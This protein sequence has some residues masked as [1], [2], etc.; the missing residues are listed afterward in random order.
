MSLRVVGKSIRE[1]VPWDPPGE[2]SGI[3]RHGPIRGEFGFSA[4]LFVLEQFGIAQIAVN[5]FES[6]NAIDTDGVCCGNCHC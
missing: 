6:I 4:A 5:F 1:P 3:H 2:S